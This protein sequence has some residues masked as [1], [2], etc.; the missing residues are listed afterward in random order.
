MRSVQSNT[1]RALHREPVNSG[2][3]FFSA[4]DAAVLETWYGQ[5]LDV[6]PAIWRQRR[7]RVIFCPFS[8]Y[9]LADRG[10]PPRFSASASTFDAAVARL[11]ALGVAVLIPDEWS[12]DAGRFARVLDPNGGIIELWEPPQ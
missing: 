10:H 6:N 4:N 3:F 11:K 8:R 5:F 12:S 9:P 1:S 7:D 2:G